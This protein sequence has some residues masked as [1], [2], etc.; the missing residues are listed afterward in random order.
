[1]LSLEAMFVSFFFFDFADMG[2]SRVERGDWPESVPP[3]GAN[4]TMSP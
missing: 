1:M 2:E 3:I 4:S